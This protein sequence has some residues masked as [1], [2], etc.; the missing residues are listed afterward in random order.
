[1]ADKRDEKYSWLARLALL[2]PV[3]YPLSTGPVC[4]LALKLPDALV[5][6]VLDL[7]LTLYFPLLWAAVTWKPFGDILRSYLRLWGV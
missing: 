3:L 1:M 2:A 6:P 5:R 7:L 4:W